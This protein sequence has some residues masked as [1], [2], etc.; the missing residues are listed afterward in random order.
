MIVVDQRV[1]E[2]SL[3]VSI[4]GGWVGTGRQQK[5][6]VSG[7]FNADRELKNTISAAI[8]KI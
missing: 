8:Q 2:Q 5:V 6:K 4:A 7:G 1:D 3:T